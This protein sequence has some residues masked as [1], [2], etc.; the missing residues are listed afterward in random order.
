M[1]RSLSVVLAAACAAS[2]GATSSWLYA[3]DSRAPKPAAPKAELTVEQARREVRLLDDMYKT[4][5]VYMNDVYVEDA[6]SVAAGQTARD[7]FE[8]MKNK[9]WHDAKLVDATGNP[10]NDENVPQDA[11]DKTAVKKILSG[12]TYYD[13]VVSEGDQK[14]LRAATLVPAVNAKCVLCHP[15]SKVGDVLGTLSF[16]IPVK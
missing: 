4:A 10:V 6:N 12:E 9:G 2:V 14:Y 16:K 3:G 8:A 5:I 15:K 7:L 11:F 1:R 13:E